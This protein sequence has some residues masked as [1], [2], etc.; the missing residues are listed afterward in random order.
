MTPNVVATLECGYAF[1]LT[2]C[3]STNKNRYA[4]IICGYVPDFI[5]ILHCSKSKTLGI[6]V[7]TE[8]FLPAFLQIVKTLSLE[9]KFLL[10]ITSRRF[11]C[12]LSQFLEQP[13]LVH[14]FHICNL[15]LQGDIYLYSISYIQ[16]E[17]LSS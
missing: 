11:S 5:T 15:Q 6:T 10:I 3:H 13:T 1:R 7:K 2:F 4:Q 17:P 9:F 12:W 8:N 16:I 14:T